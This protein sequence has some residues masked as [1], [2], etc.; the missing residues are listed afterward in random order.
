[1][2]RI[3]SAVALS[4]LVAYPAS[5]TSFWLSPYGSAPGKTQPA[6]ASDLPT[7]YNFDTQGTGSVYV[8][9]QPDSGKTLKNWSLRVESTIAS[10]LTFTTSTVYNPTLGTPGNVRWEYTHE[11]TGQVTDSNCN[12]VCSKDFMG[13]TITND[14]NDNPDNFIS[15]GIGPNT[16][17]VDEY[18]YGPNNGSGS[19]LLAKLDYTIDASSPNSTELFLQIG[20]L[21]LNNAGESSMDTQVL[22]GDMADTPFGNAGEGNRHMSSPVRDAMVQVLPEPDSDFDNDTFV[23]GKDFLIWQEHFGT[24]GT[25]P[26]GDAT[27]DGNI[28]GVDLA[29]WEFQYGITIPLV[30]SLVDSMAVPEPATWALACLAFS[31]WITRGR[32]KQ[33]LGDP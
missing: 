3:L 6:T 22:F 27:G 31:G 12:S 33:P 23:T 14:P 2:T 29:A 19:W 7:V 10:I 11:P 16:P 9:A 15:H 28:D 21:G 17:T 20:S 26:D 8:W 25:Q 18:Y 5:A 32:R 24:A 13:F 4:M 30:V 1:M